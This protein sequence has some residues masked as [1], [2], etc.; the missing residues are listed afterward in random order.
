MNNCHC[1]D[2]FELVYSDD[3]DALCHDCEESGCE[4]NA[5]TD[6]QS[7]GAYG[8][9]SICHACLS[10]HDGPC[11]SSEVSNAAQ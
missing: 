1:R 4:A 10:W 11:K 2:C 8:G 3:P 5:E 6:C 7:E 9:D